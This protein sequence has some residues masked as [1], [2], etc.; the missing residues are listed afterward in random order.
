VH[1]KDVNSTQC[2]LQE[3]I[4]ELL[5][6]QGQPQEIIKYSG[7]SKGVERRLFLE[8]KEQQE[9]PESR[10]CKEEGWYLEVGTANQW[11]H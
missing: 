5:Q 6:S 2:L 1:H 4:G 10:S 7:T 11:Q 9:L 8:L 3:S